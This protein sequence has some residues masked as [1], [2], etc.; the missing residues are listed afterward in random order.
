MKPAWRRKKR[1]RLKLFDLPRWGIALFGALA[2]LAI[3]IGA[4]PQVTQKVFPNEGWKPV[5]THTEPIVPE[6][7]AEEAGTDQENDQIHQLAGFVMVSNYRVF[8]DLAYMIAQAAVDAGEEFGI[9]PAYLIALAFV[10]STFN[11]A[12]VSESDCVGLLQINPAV[13]LADEDNKDGLTAAGI[14]GK[15]K[16]LYDPVINMRAGA[17]IL[18]HY[19]DQGKRQNSGDSLKFALTRY[20]GGDTNSHYVKFEHAVGKLYVFKQQSASRDISSIRKN[21]TD[22]AS[23]AGSIQNTVDN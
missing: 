10:E 22:S 11:Y 2:L 18:S 7:G 17:Y 9:P 19:W 8:P 6:I 20:L 16:D 23:G 14:A 3:T 15:L 1:R 13:W 12:A 21:I 4:A 5:Q